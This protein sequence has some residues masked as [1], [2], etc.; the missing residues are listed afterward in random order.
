MTK[1]RYAIGSVLLS[2]LIV[3]SLSFA[4]V[5]TMET[6]EITST[7]LGGETKTSLVYLPPSYTTSEK[8]YPSFY[9]LHGFSLDYRGLQGMRRTLDRMIQDG[10][11]GEMIAVFPDGDNSWY[12]D[13]YEPYIVSE[14]VDLIDAQYRTISDRD[15]RGVTGH[16]M[17]GF[18]A[19]HLALKFPEVFSVAVPQA[20]SYNLQEIDLYLDQP[21]RLNGIKIV[22]G[23]VDGTVP[24]GGARALDEKLTEEG[25]DHEYVEHVGGHRVFMDEESLSFLSDHLHPVHEIAR[26][27]DGTS[28]MT[29]PDAIVVGDPTLLEVEVMLDIPSEINGA[30]LGILLDLSPLGISSQLPLEHSGDGQYTLSHT[31]T[32]SRSGR[33]T[34][35]LVMET[36][37]EWDIEGTRYL[38]ATVE[39]AVHL[40]SDVYYVYQDRMESGW[41]TKVSFGELDLEAS[42]VVH[43][44]SS[45][46]AVTLKSGGNVQYTFADTEGF[47]IF[48]YTSLGFWINPGTSSMEKAFVALTTPERS[49]AVKLGEDLGITLTPDVWQKVTI[50]LEEFG[51][52]DTYLKEI[53]FQALT[54]TF[55]LDDL[56]LEVAEYRVSEA[57]ATPGSVKPDGQMSAMLTV[58]T[59]PNVLEPGDPPTVTVDLTPIGG[60]PDAVMVDNGSGGDHIAGDGI[61]TLRTTVES[62]VRNGRKDLVITSTD[63]HLR[64]IRTHLEVGVLPVD[65]VYLYRDDV[66][67]GWTLSLYKAESNPEPTDDVQ[68]GSHT[69]A[70]TLETGGRVEY[71]VENPEGLPTFG[72]IAL[73]FWIN[74]GSSS[75]EE[76][77][78]IASRHA[79]T[80]TRSSILFLEEELGLSFEPETWQPVWIPLEALELTDAN[81]ERILLAGDVTGTF[82]IDNLRFVP[83]AVPV[84]AGPTAVAVSEVGVVPTGYA[85]SQNH[86]NPFNPETT[87]RYALAEAGEVRLS[88]YNVSGQLI[89]TLVDGERA[90]GSY[91]VRWDGKDDAGRDVA[92]GVYVG[93]MEVGGFRT[94]RKMVLVR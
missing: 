61:Y 40:A 53:R 29:T 72:Y 34:L 66:E 89:R 87:I 39:L 41:A 46:Q 35:P 8:E 31:I 21:V 33:H 57:V 63:R 22:H 90:V 16:S 77:K 64:E 55:Y 9:A 74:P 24:V 71:I 60:A 78:I 2:V 14:L 25:I 5:G 93:R 7:A 82:Y 1:T 27:R 51:L 92:S 85:L 37:F 73:E 20:G 36:G 6:G 19:M 38:L 54:G 49:W 86:P 11:I 56:R 10:E 88:L 62:E 44:G 91:S 58:Q 48:G 81:L 67:E 69:Q 43:E 15:S 68:R 80:I 30:L 76:L 45:A 18:G 75:V 3:S 52:T 65:D 79:G 26:L 50:P 84:P 42:E 70:I 94:V 4:Q 59:T 13:E 47:S 17:G 28:A 12:L 32:P 83:E 23:A